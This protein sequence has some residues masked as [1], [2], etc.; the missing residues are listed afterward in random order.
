VRVRIKGFDGQGRGKGFLKV[1]GSMLSEREEVER[2]QKG[3][4]GKGKANGGLRTRGA[5]AME[6]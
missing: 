5:E 2:T 3:A 6:V 1:E 4:K